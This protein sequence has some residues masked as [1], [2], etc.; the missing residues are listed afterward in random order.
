ML[1]FRLEVH[2]WSARCGKFLFS[3]FVSFGVIFFLSYNGNTLYLTAF[4]KEEMVPRA[5][6]INYFLK[7]EVSI[8]LHCRLCSICYTAVR[9]KNCSKSISAIKTATM[10]NTD[11]F[12]YE[13]KPSR[14]TAK[15]TLFAVGEDE[16]TQRR[17]LVSP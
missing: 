17:T 6:V 14:A 5:P 1:L 3:Y 10:K 8:T 16:G 2:G 4:P 7:S 9:I 13:G 15:L 12:R 11:D